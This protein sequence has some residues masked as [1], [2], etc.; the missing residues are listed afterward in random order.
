M[1]PLPFHTLP[2]HSSLKRSRAEFDAVQE[3]IVE[4]KF[5]TLCATN[6]LT[7]GKRKRSAVPS[8]LSYKH[9]VAPLPEYFAKVKK[10]RG[11]PLKGLKASK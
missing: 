7:A 1:I 4:E 2:P 5:D 10:T 8:V 3:A 6:A 11:N 9:I